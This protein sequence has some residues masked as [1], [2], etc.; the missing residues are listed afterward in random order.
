[1]KNF[2]KMFMVFFVIANLSQIAFCEQDSKSLGIGIDMDFVSKYIWRGQVI[3]NEPVFQPSLNFSYQNWQANIWGSVDMTNPHDK[4]WEF[5][6]VDYTLTYSNNF[7]VID[8][9][10]Y[11]AGVI[12]YR[13]PG[14][15]EFTTTEAFF[16]ISAE[17]F[18]NPSLT[19]YRDIDEAKGTYFSL[20]I[21]HSIENIFEISKE[22]PVGLA[23][24][25]NLG[26]AN[27]K[28]NSFYWSNDIAEINNSGFNDFSLVAAFPFEIRGWTIAPS[29]SYITLLRNDIRSS[30]NYSKKSDFVIA[31]VS[32]SKQF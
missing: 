11:T 2:V 9:L 32:L 5:T 26:F 18:L 6:E 19:V 25:A 30:D 14:D 21:S 7:P 13:L 23:L 3:N 8:W 15:E 1:M 31:G 4:D 17:V 22:I 27:K 12:C 20:G 29:V 28:Y 16:G 10:N 24:S